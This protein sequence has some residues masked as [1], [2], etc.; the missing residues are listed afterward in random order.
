M[1][2]TAE[3]IRREYDLHLRQ[4]RQGVRSIRGGR[5]ADLDSLYLRCSWEANYA[6]I[7]NLLELEWEYELRTFEFPIRRGTRFYTPDFYLNKVDQWHEVKGRWDSKSK[8][9]LRRFKKYFPD[10]FA[11]LYIVTSDIWGK[12]KTAKS[13][14]TFLICTLRLSP[15]RIINYTALSKK[16]RSIITGWEK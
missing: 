7:L 14:R 5:R 13:V 8:T 1:A 11:K 10:E 2:K 4:Q 6:R 15:E 3:Q 16:Y 12:S 9:M